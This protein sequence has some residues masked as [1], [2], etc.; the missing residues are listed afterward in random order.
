MT[1]A[2]G[3]IFKDLALAEGGYVPRGPVVGRQLILN[4]LIS[5]EWRSKGI[6][7]CCEGDVKHLKPRRK[8]MQVPW[9][10]WHNKH[11][12]PELFPVECAANP[13]ECQP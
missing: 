5:N 3:D 12:F 8:D 7:N 1:N 10:A 2:Y 13:K 4:P 11:R 9:F 6:R